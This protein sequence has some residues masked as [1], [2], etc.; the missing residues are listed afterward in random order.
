MAPCTNSARL[1]INGAYYG[2]YAA[3]ES[4]DAT[5]VEQFFPGNAGGDLFKGGSIA[6]TNKAAPN[7][8]RLKQFWA[9]KDIAAIAEH[10]RPA[11]HRARMGGGG[12]HQRRRRLLRRVTQLLHLRPGR[13][14]IHL[15]AQRR[16]HDLR[17][18]RALHASCRSSST[19]STGGRGRPSRSRPGSTSRRDERSDLARRATR[20]RWRRRSGSGTPPRCSG[21]RRRLVGAD[22]DGG[23]G[24]PAEVGDDGR[25][26][27]WRS[28]TRAT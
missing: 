25:R 3:E 26:Q 13:G 21:W 6:A 10:R 12:R 16:R 22:R 18:D 23:R 5:L 20:R 9:A 2:L 7:W 17:M 19:R 14:G 28:P 4:K 15:A 27:T 11:K 24:R 1:N 8:A